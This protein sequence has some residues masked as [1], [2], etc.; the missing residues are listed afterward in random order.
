MRR[1]A[2]VALAA[3]LALAGCTG[4]TGGKGGGGK[5]GEEGK[6][7][8][9][10]KV[11][12][13]PTS[14]G[15]HKQKLDVGTVGHREYLLHVPSK[16]ADGRWEDGRPADRPALVIA[17]HGG[18]ATMAKMRELTGFDRLSDEHGFLVAYPDGV[19]TT[20]NAGDCCG[21]AKIGNVDDV[22]F[23][24]T[25]IDRLTGAGLAD[26]GRVYVTGFSNGAG[27]AYRM[28][29]ERPGKVAAI[30]VVEGALV[31]RCEPARPVSAMIF[32]GTADGN[33][34]FNGGGNRDFNDR[35]PFPPVSDAVDFWRRV[36]GLPEP[37]ERVRARSRDTRCESTGKGAKGVAVTF[38]RIEGGRH[39][40]PEG[41]S[42][43]L[44]SFF[45]AHP[46]AG[47]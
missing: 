6:G 29:C 15:T 1:I 19:M 3:S 5:G 24:G 38:C 14:A 13:I 45:A 36:G 27:M 34:P 37:R 21:P 25:L 42:A 23:L 26:P 31:T 16:V 2:L 35:R 28:A 44:W 22:G 10:A 9:P 43:M 32:H 20:W 7:G 33:V 47:T 39:R 4:E 8:R 41:A 11:R 18:L 12:G 17:L 30:G 40:W 46:R